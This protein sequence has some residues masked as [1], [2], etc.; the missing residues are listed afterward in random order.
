MEQ[1]SYSSVGTSVEN[2]IVE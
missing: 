1:V 2:Y